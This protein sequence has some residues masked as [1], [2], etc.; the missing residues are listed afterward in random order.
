MLESME[1]RAGKPYEIPSAN[2]NEVFR[3]VPQPDVEGRPYMASASSRSCTAGVRVSLTRSH[4]MDFVR[5]IAEDWRGWSDLRQFTAHPHGHQYPPPALRLGASNDGQGHVA[6]R[7]EIG[8]PW[9]PDAA[10]DNPSSTSPFARTAPGSWYTEI[11]MGL[12]AGQLGRIARK[13]SALPFDSAGS[14]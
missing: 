2:G 7:V 3:L 6:L 9:I 12:K 14:H 1:E 11:I 8:Y 10:S 5:G 4:F 13:A